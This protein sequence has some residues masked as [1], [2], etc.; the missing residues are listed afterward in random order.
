MR[1]KLTQDEFIEKAKSIHGERYD[2]SNTVYVRSA[3][4]VLIHCNKCGK[5]FEQSANAHLMGHGCNYCAQVERNKG[6]ILNT[7][8]FIR[9]AKLLFGERFDYSMVKYKNI[10]KPVEIICREHGPFLTIPGNHL[11]GRPGCPKCKADKIK[12]RRT[13]I[14]NYDGFSKSSGKCKQIWENILTRCYGEGEQRRHPT[15][16]GCSVC[17]EWMT[18]SNFEKWFNENYREGY[19]IEKD[20]IVKGNRVYSPETCCF[21][22]RRIN[23]LLTNRRRFRGALPIGVTLSESGMRYRASYDRDGK[24]TLIGYYGSSEEAFYAYKKAKECYI[25]EVAQEYFEKG[26]ITER[27]RD[28]LFCY[29]VEISD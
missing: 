16:C 19:E 10:N 13:R 12:S 27:V 22:P 11:N 21:V 14:G 1:R 26:L 15:Y 28:A 29:E 6:N 5:D 18:F 4:K 20:I 9:R 8:E 7:A 17:E 3:L 24:S 25:K 23:I 2:Y